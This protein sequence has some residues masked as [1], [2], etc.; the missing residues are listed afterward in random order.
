MGK[1]ALLADMLEPGVLRILAPNPS[2]MTGPGTNTYV[3]G[4]DEV[5]ILDPGPA[6]AGHLENVAAAAG[7]R[8]VRAILVSHAHL[9]HSEGAR[10]LSE[11]VG[12]PIFGFGPPTAGRLPVMDELAAQGLMAGGEGVDPDFTPDHLL[13]DGD[14]IALKGRAIEVLWTPGHFAGH[15]SFAWG[16]AVFTGD[17]VMEWSTSLI[18]PPDGDVTR[19]MSSCAR[20]LQRDD[21][22]FYPGHGAA[23]TMPAARLQWLM[24]H[25][26]EREEQILAA[27]GSTPA[28][29]AVITERVYPDLRKELHPAA[30]RN[31]LAHLVDLHERTL[32]TAVP[33][34]GLEARFHRR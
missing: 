5:V 27:L 12:C 13:C 31:V 17:L 19:Y 16:D 11:A 2:P 8:V 28:D 24:A 15:L 33:R 22:I 1:K 9:D 3:I 25:R 30:Q 32:V 14:M 26:L 6:N 10:A 23:V 21:R 20:L 29:V 4:H 7:D 34:L 18:S